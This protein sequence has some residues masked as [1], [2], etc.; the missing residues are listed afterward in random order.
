MK[1]IFVY[2]HADTHPASAGQPDFVRSLSPVGEAESARVGNWLKQANPQ[3][4]QVICSSA[5]RAETTLRLTLEAMGNPTLP[6]RHEQR[7]YLAAPSEIFRVLNELNPTAQA[8]MVVGHNPGLHQF[9]LQLAQK[10]K[11]EL[12][13]LAFQ[14]PTASLAQFEVDCDTW[15]Q[16]SPATPA[17]F[18]RFT[19]PSD[20]A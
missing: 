11:E 8:V 10:S 7:L 18:V 19:T 4:Q 1:H 16:F 13:K 6:T 5:V 14:F 12:G 17:R 2:R 20:I 9:A 3:P 15:S